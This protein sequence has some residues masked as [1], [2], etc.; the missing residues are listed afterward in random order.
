MKAKGEKIAVITAYDYLSA[1]LMEE[2]GIPVI[3]VG[4]SLGNVVAGLPNTLGVTM[5]QMVY[6]TTIVKRAVSGALLVAD[7]PY[8]SYQVGVDEA[9][10]NAG[11]FI[12]EAG[13]DAVK[14]EGGRDV[15]ERIMPA[16]RRSQIPV[17]GHLGLTPQSINRFGGYKIQGRDEESQERMIS[18]A[19]FLQDTGCFSMVLEGI[20]EEL[21]KRITEKLDIPT[22]GIGAGR[23]TDGQVLVY[24]DVLGLS[25]KVPKFVRKYADL[26]RVIVDSIIKYIDD[27]QKNEFPSGKEIYD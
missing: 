15:L 19:L 12:K 24:H 3:L 27:V 10:H 16:L 22:I 20:P 11:R 26:N 8:L 14:M 18:D 13:A 25:D 9:V 7:M 23:H 6:H 5:D 17:M 4:D 2:A 21:G 1:R